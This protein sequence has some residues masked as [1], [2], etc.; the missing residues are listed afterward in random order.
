MLARVVKKTDFAVFQYFMHTPLHT[1]C[2]RLG[3]LADWLFTCPLQV[4]TPFQEGQAVKTLVSPPPRW[5]FLF[6]KALQNA[7]CQRDKNL[8]DPL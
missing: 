1:F 2:L 5:A 4:V 3:C 8:Q 6:C 7:T